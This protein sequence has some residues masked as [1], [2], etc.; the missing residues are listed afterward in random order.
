MSAVRV[1]NGPGVVDQFVAPASFISH[2]FW[3]LT[4]SPTFQ[5][6]MVNFFKSVAILEGLPDPRKVPGRTVSAVI[7]PACA[8]AFHR[9]G[10]ENIF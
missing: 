6:R 1:L 10:L 9:L 4:G 8:G 3:R 2:S 5:G 7:T